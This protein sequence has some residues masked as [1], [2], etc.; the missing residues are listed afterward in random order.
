MHCKNRME[1]VQGVVLWYAKTAVDNIGNYGTNLRTN[2]WRYP[3]LQ[4]RM[5][6]IDDKAPKKPK[7]LKKVWTEDGYMLFWKAPKGKGWEN[8][9]YKYVVYKFGPDEEIDLDNPMKIIA[10]T[11]QTALG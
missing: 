2:Y 3:S 1:N 10:I 6:F 4:P 9:A 11:Y 7:R 5:P 8:E